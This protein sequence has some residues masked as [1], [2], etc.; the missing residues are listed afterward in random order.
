MTNTLKRQINNGIAQPLLSL[1]IYYVSKII[2]VAMQGAFS[3]TVLVDVAIDVAHKLGWHDTAYK[4]G[5]KIF[6]H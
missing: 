6:S 3:L 1:C 4:N 2:S 5:T